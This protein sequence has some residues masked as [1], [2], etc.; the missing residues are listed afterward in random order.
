MPCFHPLTG[1]HGK[2]VSKNGKRPIVFNRNRSF[3]GIPVKLPCG[4]CI[5]CRLERSRQW[6]MRCVHEASL[7]EANCFITLTYDDAHCPKDGSLRFEHWQKFMKRFRK[8]FGSGVR[9]YHCCIGEW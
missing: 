2:E 9:F 3:D 6:A 1:Y 8:R 7:H 5:G 4:R